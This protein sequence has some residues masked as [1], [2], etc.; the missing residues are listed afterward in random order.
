MD[1]KILSDQMKFK[2]RVSAIFIRDNKLLV[3]KY[4]D[5][6]Y[7]LPGGSVEIGETSKEAI[8]RE[9]K[10]EI[11]LNF[12]ILSFAGIAENFFTNLKGQKTHSIDFY[13]YVKLV[14]DKDYEFIDYN[15]I[16]N[17]KGRIVEHKFSWININKLNEIQL[18]PLE[19]RDKIKS[20]E[21]NFH[22]IINDI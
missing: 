9:L 17:D 3:N 18:L 19:V 2:Y 14:D 22:I 6:S 21:L 10:E 8:L 4:D 1:I 11:N 12:E 5:N 20:S 7:C 13:Y 16:E 15:R